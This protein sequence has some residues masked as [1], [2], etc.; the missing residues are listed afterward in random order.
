MNE[1]RWLK[2][3][4]QRNPVRE[5]GIEGF[6]M[7][8]RRLLGGMA[9]TAAA[10]TLLGGRAFAEDRPIAQLCWDGYADP[11]MAE[12]WK[13]DT[14][15]TL[16]PE[17]HI[18]DPQ[19]LNRLRAGE[20]KNF[21]FIN[22]NDPWAKN[23]FWPEKLIVECDKARFEPLYSQMVERFRPPYKRAYSA[24]GNHLLGVVQRYETF[25]FVINTDKI[26]VDT[27]EKEGWSLFSN[28]DFAQRFG[29]LAY[30]DWNVIDIC[31]GAGLHPFKQH[32]DDEVAKFKETAE[33][34]VKNAKLITTDFVQLNLAILNGEIDMYFT[35]GTYS[36]AG[37]RREGNNNLYA[38]SPRSGPADGKGA[39]IWIEL[40]SAI[41][42]PNLH[43]KIFDFLE[44]ITKPEAAYIAAT[45]N[46]NIQP[47]SQMAQPDVLAKFSK[48][49]LVAMQYDTLA[50]R[51]SNAVEFD[52]VPDYDKLLDI[53]TAA[54]RARG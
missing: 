35:G 28:P 29:I 7:N 6:R 37:A 26:A 34:W 15:G 8:R 22:V 47:V 12:L 3:I 13:K 11:R 19:S 25:D 33:L 2:Q 40:N 39:V 10:T 51:I 4:V 18:S 42:N 46:G 20:T 45:A 9:A 54:R 16:K 21:D 36:I 43:P 23:F 1:D 44:W 48:E 41:N 27:A 31:L 24:D 32:T 53:Y 49:E 52:A 17:I 50:H 38:I 30:D 5:A 14:G